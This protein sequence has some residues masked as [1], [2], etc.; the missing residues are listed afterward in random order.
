MLWTIIAILFAL[1][2]GGPNTS[3]ESSHPRAPFLA[4]RFGLRA[5]SALR[6]K[7]CDEASTWGAIPSCS[8]ASG[9]MESCPTVS[10][11]WPSEV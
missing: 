9:T 7:E 10:H 4:W 6:G 11:S 8:G 1:R 5:S 2:V 3:G